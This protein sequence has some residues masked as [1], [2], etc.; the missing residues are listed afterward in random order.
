MLSSIPQLI[1]ASVPFPP[2]NNNQHHSTLIQFFASEYECL[3]TTDCLSQTS[4]SDPMFN[5]MIF[6]IQLEPIHSVIWPCVMLNA[7]RC[8]INCLQLNNLYFNP[9]KYSWQL[10]VVRFNIII[11]VSVKTTTK[12]YVFFKY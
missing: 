12:I 4:T 5:A 7:S 6:K 10:N 9:G 2:P 11:H 8:S 3:W 1:G